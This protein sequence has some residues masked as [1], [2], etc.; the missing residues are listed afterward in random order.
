L[1]T[2]VDWNTGDLAAR[3]LTTGQNRRLTSKETWGDDGSFALNSTPSPDGRRVAYGWE[4]DERQT[5]EA[6]QFELRLVGIDG[7]EPRVLYTDPEVEGVKPSEWSP[8]G[9]H[10]LTMLTRRDH[11]TQIALISATDG[12]VRVLRTLAWPGPG[13]MGFSPDG[14]YVV[15]DRPAR[16]DAE[17]RDIYVLATG[18]SAETALVQHPAQDIVM[19]W[20]PDGRHVLF[21]SDRTGEMSVWLAPVSDG[22]PAGEPLLVRRDPELATA[23]PMG[24]T[25]DGAF[26]YGVNA[27]ATDVYLASIDPS[28]GGATGAPALLLDHFVGT[29]RWAD[30]TRDGTA[31]VY[32][33]KRQSGPSN[34][35]ELL[36]VRTVATGAEHVVP[37]RLQWLRTPRWSPDGRY[38]VGRGQDQN[39]RAGIFRVDPQSGEA[40]TLVEGSGRFL[41]G[42]SADPASVVYWIQDQSHQ[43]LAIARQ[44]LDN[45]E[46]EDLVRLEWAPWT[47]L[48]VA[49]VSPDGR[50]VAFASFPSQGA[51]STL[52]VVSSNGGE[53]RQLFQAPRE[54][55]GAY[56]GLGLAWSTDSRHVFFVLQGGGK[57]RLMRVAAT[58]GAAQET[59]V[60]MDGMITQPRALPDGQRIGFTAGDQ[61]VEVWIMENFLPQETGPGGRFHTPSRR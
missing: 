8:D 30:W 13:K 44:R 35:S 31:A 52:Q 42:W 50:Q 29:N 9:R 49:D 60:V 33:A 53:V 51:P 6:T 3:D 15:Y 19:G 38:I 34:E 23:V 27:S 56:V 37:S 4:T 11:S 57:A 18:G 1:L 55:D 41:A 59:G 14:R 5:K 25:Q 7:G 17:Q 45:G 46:S 24:F 22:K 32:M 47:N 61:A 21:G 12:A 58:G 26:L 40:T 16:E 10:I 28:S 39:G 43:T 36:I 20:A 54:P 2:F 48:Y